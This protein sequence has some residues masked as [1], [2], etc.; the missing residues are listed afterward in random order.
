MKIKVKVKFFGF[1]A[2]M[3]G[4]DHV[5]EFDEGITLADAIEKIFRLYNVGNFRLANEYSPIGYVKVFLNGKIASRKD[6]LHDGDEITLYP[7][8][9]G[10]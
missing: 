3:V 2:R 9:S 8:I 7:P 5:L 4:K 10:G 6:V 1:L